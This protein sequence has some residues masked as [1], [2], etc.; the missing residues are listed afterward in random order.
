MKKLHGVVDA[1]KS[2]ASS[3]ALRLGLVL[4]LMGSMIATAVLV[5]HW[6]FD[7]TIDDVTIL[8]E[9]WLPQLRL[10]SDLIVETYEIKDGISD[11]LL[12]NS[13][14]ELAVQFDGVDR[15]LRSLEQSAE[16]HGAATLMAGLAR[17]RTA[18][19]S[20]RD[21]RAAEFQ[22]R[23]RI[24]GFLT[25][26]DSKA[27]ILGEKLA[28]VFD[29]AH[30]R[31]RTA[32]ERTI[33]EIDGSLTAIVDTD[34]AALKIAFHAMAETNLLLG[35]EIARSAIGDGAFAGKF[36]DIGEPNF[37]RLEA[38]LTGLA[39]N[40]AVDLDQAKVAQIL[41]LIKDSRSGGGEMIWQ[42]PE[43]VLEALETSQTL[44]AATI[45]DLMGTLQDDGAKATRTNADSVR[46]LLN[47]DVENLH[48]LALLDAALKS[49][50][51]AA[52]FVGAAQDGQQLDERAQR[53]AATAQKVSRYTQ[54]GGAALAEEINAMLAAV[55]SSS[56]IPRLRAQAIALRG[57]V[58]DAA[59]QAAAS[60]HD[61]AMISANLGSRIRTDIESAS[62]FLMAKT[63][64]AETIMVMVAI[65]GFLLSLLAFVI[66]QLTVIRPVRQLCR[67]TERLAWGDLD[68]IERRAS[69]AGEIGRMFRAL[70]V[71]RDDLVRKIEMEKEAQARQLRERADKEAME[72]EQRARE[73]RKREQA[74]LTAKAEAARL[75]KE[76][77]ERR[78]LRAQVDKERQARIR[79]SEELV[80]ALAQGLTNLADG[81]L[82]A[83][84]LDPFPEAYEG[85]R[86]DFNSA[87][88]HLSQVI[89][90]I[91][92][93]AS[94]IDGSSAEMSAAAE[95]LATRTENTAAALEEASNALGQL[96]GSVASAAQNAQMAHST[97]RDAKARAEQG[98]E[99]V[100]QT[101][102]AM[103]KIE[104]SSENIARITDV[105][106]D[107]AFQTNLLA[108][109]A[110][111]EA[112]R[113]GDAG[114][115]FAVV[116]MEVRALAQ[117]SS[118]AAKEI[119]SLIAEAETNVQIGSELVVRTGGALESI[120]ETVA[121]AS[122]MVE[123]I[124]VSAQS[125]A[126][127][128]SEINNSVNHI[129]QATQ[130][131]AALFQ[132]TSA[133]VLVLEKESATLSEMVSSFRLPK[134]LRDQPGI[135]ALP[136]SKALQPD[137]GSR[138]DAGAVRTVHF[139]DAS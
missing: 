111:V 13:S 94:T 74:A 70:T 36:Q 4:T 109:N 129:D 84:I 100:E 43:Q 71:F 115:G 44:I 126:D 57:N 35:T 8:N 40:P 23:A 39:E 32:G 45:T 73:L 119:N 93:S 133:L 105:I 80:S 122:N 3:I 116:A 104:T 75:E 67:T 64:R 31:L 118:D 38:M 138:S 60:I 19:E 87:I 37:I 83:A 79:E 95:D 1:L 55:N 18:I 113:A 121:R 42:R 10:S 65:G 63:E 101:A 131:N 24:D 102:L 62:Q 86:H 30:D 25:D 50:V 2:A 92:A 97:A 112:A 66:T 14:D 54:Y 85:L 21:L 135:S 26:L 61:S 106:E 120:A 130:R 72:A 124:A 52:F 139:R 110:G 15:Q 11:V 127:G 27:T 98:T 5:G 81:N 89:H 22:N 82:D 56:G 51:A 46:S 53:M 107:I 58:R 134:T 117:R 76:A 9:S 69:Q 114:R 33:F 12:A 77:K 78:A 16:G 47:G 103:A 7:K 20:F 34:V 108:L 137:L 59:N 136:K 91:S 88:T 90:Q 125:Q 17:V 68:P 28:A 128:V 99:V 29:L 49:F 6:I 132:E 96:T 48:N 123:E 41:L